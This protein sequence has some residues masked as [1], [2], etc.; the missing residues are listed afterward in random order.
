MI[1]S[2]TKT[3]GQSQVAA[4]THRWQHFRGTS[5]PSLG[6]VPDAPDISKH[7]W[8][9]QRQIWDAQAIADESPR[10]GGSHKN[11]TTQ[12]ILL[13]TITHTLLE[14]QP[15]DTFWVDDSMFQTFH[16]QFRLF[17]LHF[18]VYCPL[19]DDLRNV[20]LSQMSLVS[21]DFLWLDDYRRLDVCFSKGTLLLQRAWERRQSVLIMSKSL[22]FMM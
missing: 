1:L 20:L 2:A 16:V 3:S 21:A 11:N 13:H 8:N 15:V 6:A 7:V 17:S 4:Q 18:M 14:R 22:C 5:W 19:Y 9:N 10:G 12:Q